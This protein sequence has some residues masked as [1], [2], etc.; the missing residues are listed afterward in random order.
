M[1]G[2]N[3]IEGGEGWY[4]FCCNCILAFL[5]LLVSYTCL[6]VADLFMLRYYLLVVLED[7]LL[8]DL[9][10]REHIEYLMCA[11]LVVGSLL[12]NGVSNVTLLVLLGIYLVVLDEH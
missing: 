1:E 7:L 4:R 2:Y 12:E 5:H 11:L 6:E 8:R 10:V 3:C 9:P